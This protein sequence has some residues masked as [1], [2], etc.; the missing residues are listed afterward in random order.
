MDTLENEIKNPP[1]YTQGGIQPLD[2]IVSNGMKFRE[3][4]V[5]KY[6]TRHE[7]KDGLK[8]LL[9]ARQYLDDL[10]AEHMEDDG[11]GIQDV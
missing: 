9:K 6:I 10:I 1:H 2:F 4:N 3:G 7:Y 11:G 8:D 5:V